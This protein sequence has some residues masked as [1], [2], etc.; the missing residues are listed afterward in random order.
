[1]PV[2]RRDTHDDHER[3]LER[4]DF[5]RPDYHTGLCFCLASYLSISEA[6]INQ[7]FHPGKGDER[8]NHYGIENINHKKEGYVTDKGGY[9]RRGNPADTDTSQ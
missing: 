3:L 2:T 4:K 9:Q 1:M 6:I 5:F 8:L 7:L